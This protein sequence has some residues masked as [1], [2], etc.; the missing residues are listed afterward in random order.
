MD[1]NNWISVVIAGILAWVSVITMWVKE[2]KDRLHT[3]LTMMETRIDMLT[4]GNNSNEKQLAV[5]Q[6]CQ[7]NINRELVE[8]KED[9]KAVLIAVRK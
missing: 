2:S 7:A 4:T 8:I 9:I 6:T 5:L 3:R 1:T